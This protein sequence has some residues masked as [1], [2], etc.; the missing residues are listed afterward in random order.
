MTLK[1]V[2]SHAFVFVLTIVLGGLAGATLVRL[3]PGFDFD[4]RELNSHYA[5]ESI[6][7]MREARA[8]E[9]NLLSFYGHYLGAMAHGDLGI[10]RT[11]NRPVAQLLRERAPATL[12]T[13][14]LGLL[15][16]WMLGFAFA[17]PEV[18]FGWRSLDLF[19]GFVS[20]FFLSIPAAVLA[21]VLLFF[22][23]G[24]W[25]AIAFIIFPRI[26][27]Y[28]RNLMLQS[29]A[30]PHVLTARAKGLRTLRI[31]GWHVFP[32]AS[33]QIVALAGISVSMALGAAIPVEVICDVPGIGQLAWQAALGRDL[34]L[35]VNLTLLITVITL[36]ANWTSDFTLA[37]RMRPHEAP[38]MRT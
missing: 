27:R 15:A 9:R 16:A 34:P 32:A 11:F 30:M 31:L 26:Y 1:N 19:S 29:Y 35:L 17:I 38:D 36:L 7:A 28:T 21:L 24:A 23:G 4:E 8:G 14:G 3:A 37:A 6:R 12:Q 2:A 20:S 5:P 22:G 18:M 13:A 10:S 33:P 25:M